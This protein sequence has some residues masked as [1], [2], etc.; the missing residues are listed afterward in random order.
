MFRLTYLSMR[1]R[2]MSQRL[3]KSDCHGTRAEILT[4]F[5]R[6]AAASQALVI[7]HSCEKRQPARLRQLEGIRIAARSGD[8]HIKYASCR[9][10]NSLQW[11]SQTSLRSAHR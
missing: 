6:A 4:Q 2:P 1:D 10:L 11:R 9:R 5:L 3:G 7:P 8:C